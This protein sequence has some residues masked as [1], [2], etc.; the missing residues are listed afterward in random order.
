MRMTIWFV[1]L[2]LI[3]VVAITALVPR[4]MAGRETRRSTNTVYIVLIGASIWAGMADFRSNNTMPCS[5]AYCRAHS[6]YSTRLSS[7]VI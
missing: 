7:P 2:A 3:I 1:L 6:L 5:C 4:R